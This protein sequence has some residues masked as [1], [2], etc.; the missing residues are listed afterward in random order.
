MTKDREPESHSAT[1]G[2]S[3]EG[4]GHESL[5]ESGPAS[6]PQPTIAATTATVVR[7]FHQVLI[8]RP[9]WLD[10]PGQTVVTTIAAG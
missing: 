4:F 1:S 2:G 9:L 10:L 7:P 8:A 6:E 3:P 5:D